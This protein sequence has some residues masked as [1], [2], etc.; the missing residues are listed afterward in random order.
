MLDQYGKD[1]IKILE[2]LKPSKHP[3]E[4]FSDWLVLTAATLYSWKKDENVEKEFSEVAKHYTPAEM[5]KH[6][7]LLEL[8]VSALEKRDQDFLGEIFMNANISNAKAGQFFTPYEVSLLSAK[9]TIGNDPIENKGRLL[10]INDPTCGAG[11]MLIAGIEVLKEKNFN[12]QRD[13]LF[14]AQDIDA[15]CARMCFIQLT[16]MAAPAVIY[17]MNTLTMQEYWHRETL[18]Y[19]VSDIDWR[20]RAESLIDKV[21]SI[22]QATEE[23]EQEQVQ[24]QMEINIPASKKL[25]QMELF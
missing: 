12:Y 5:E 15:R 18:F 13:A 1:F 22:G 3:Y 7:Q 6:S 19:H 4:V 21:K 2:H 24:E 14:I 17:C 23:P 8:T 10:Q 11:G 25:K 16:L 20:L 9:I